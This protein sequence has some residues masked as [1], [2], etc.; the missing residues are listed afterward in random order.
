MGWLVNTTQH[1]STNTNSATTAPPLYHHRTYLPINQPT[2]H[3][4]ASFYHQEVDHVT[5]H[6][7]VEVVKD[8]HTPTN[9][10]R[11]SSRAQVFSQYSNSQQG[12]GHASSSSISTAPSA[13]EDYSYSAGGASGSGSG[14]ASANGPASVR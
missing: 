10:R 5:A 6:V 9:R 7:V 11:E 8:P 13:S 1:H 2:A 3:R 4:Y 14:S 12:R